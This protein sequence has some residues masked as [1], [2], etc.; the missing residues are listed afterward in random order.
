[1]CQ[2]ITRGSACLQNVSCLHVSAAEEPEP[3]LR[4]GLI[5]LPSEWGHIHI[6]HDLYQ[7]SRCLNLRR[8]RLFEGYSHLAD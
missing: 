7:L 5:Y 1:M 3:S 8:L 2:G 6:R 4:N